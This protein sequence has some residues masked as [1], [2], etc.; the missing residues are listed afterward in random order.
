LLKDPKML[1]MLGPLALRGIISAAHGSIFVNF[2]VSTINETDNGL[3]LTE[4]EKIEKALMTY[5]ALGV[6]SVL[7]SIFVGMITDRFG[8]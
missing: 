6:G 4:D 2:W 5:T 8:Y 3:V 1:A 7:G